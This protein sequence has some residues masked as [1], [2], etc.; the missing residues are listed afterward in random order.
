V[1]PPGAPHRL[2]VCEAFGDAGGGPPEY[3]GVTVAWFDD[4]EAGPRVRGRMDTGVGPVRRY[5][6]V[7][8]RDRRGARPARP[9]YI[10]AR[11]E[12]HGNEQKVKMMSVA[13]RAD[14]LSPAEFSE[15]WKTQSGR[16]GDSK[17]PPEV[18][19]MAYAQNHP[20][21]VAEHEWPYDAVNEVWFDDRKGCSA[22]LD[23]F[24]AVSNEAAT[25]KAGS[26]FH[27]PT[28]TTWQ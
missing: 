26:I 6:R 10:D 15:R 5:R 9:D 20:V 21:P 12:Q 23:Y 25:S 16:H 24:A 22:R 1:K 8:R 13:K 27:P 17:M 19:G 3:D 18:L 7:R 11:W 2:T 14:G 4:V 28:S